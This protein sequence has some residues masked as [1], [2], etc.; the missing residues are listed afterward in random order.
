MTESISEVAR[1][2]IRFE[3]AISQAISFVMRNDDNKFVNL[4]DRYAIAAQAYEYLR[5]DGLV[6]DLDEPAPSNPTVRV[7]NK[8]ET[9]KPTPR[10]S[11]MFWTTSTGAN[12]D[13]RYDEP[14][15]APVMPPRDTSKIS[16]FLSWLSRL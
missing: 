16:R 15:Y 5:E 14:E 7:I 13:I 9:I 8:V 4:T 10:A 12:G 3:N 2:R 6:A 1:D 11:S